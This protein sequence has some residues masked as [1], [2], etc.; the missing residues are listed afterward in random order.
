MVRWLF[1]LALSG[2]NWVFG[3]DPTTAADPPA[4]ANPAIDED[5][6][7]LPNAEDNC[8]GVAN[9][10]QADLVDEDG[11]G[12]AC[13]PDLHNV[14]SIVARYFFNEPVDATHF[15][16]AAETVP[17]AG[18]VEISYSAGY[19]YFHLADLPAVTRGTLTIEAGLE[20]IE[21]EPGSAV[22]VYT[23]GPDLHTA[24]VE[25]RPSAFLAVYNR[26]PGGCESPTGCDDDQVAALP[27]RLVIQLRSNDGDPVGGLKAIL[28]GTGNDVHFDSTG[29]I[30][31]RCGV[32][33]RAVR[34]RLHHVIVYEGE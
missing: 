19:V 14:N 17:R 3:L 28:A 5:L 21:H 7:G 18:F 26:P 11:V 15:T 22:G 16:A 27:P 30:S 10:D 31:S 4:D 8:P 20:L 2:C 29:T 12:D 24:L 13:D 9:P 6:D 32:V 1:V 25:L 33:A 34:A 23:D